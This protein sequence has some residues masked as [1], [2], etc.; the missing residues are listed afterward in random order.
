MINWV[1]YGMNIERK[2]PLHSLVLDWF[3]QLGTLPVWK[4]TF[5]KASPHRNCGKNE[6]FNETF[7]VRSN[8][9]KVIR[10]HCL[11]S[12]IMYFWIHNNINVFRMY[13]KLYV[14]N[15]GIEII[16]LNLYSKFFRCVFFF[17]HHFS[18]FSL[19][20]ILFS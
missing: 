8:N 19:L 11:F 17:F 18:F 6:T 4:L 20:C 7:D 3:S 10:I 12:F 2:P 14:N 16:A 1:N 5:A 9:T 15:W 13:S